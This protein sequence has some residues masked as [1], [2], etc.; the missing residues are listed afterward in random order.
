MKQMLKFVLQV[1]VFSQLLCMFCGCCKY[2]NSLCIEKL[3][4]HLYFKKKSLRDDVYTLRLSSPVIGFCEWKLIML[5]LGSH[6]SNSDS[7]R[8][9]QVDQWKCFIK[10]IDF[11]EYYTS[12]NRVERVE[13]LFFHPNKGKGS[14]VTPSPAVSLYIGNNTKTIATH[15]FIPIYK[16]L[17]PNDCRSCF[18]SHIGISI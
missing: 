7:V 11:T 6:H 4:V 5:N 10:A 1:F 3:T 17:R 13:M 2:S 9:I 12:D 16:N 14:V 18:I 15:S 8:K